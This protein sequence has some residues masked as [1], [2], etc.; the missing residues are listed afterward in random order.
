MGVTT[1]SGYRRRTGPR[2]PPP[3]TPVAVIARGTTPEQRIARTTL[4]GLAAVDLGTT[5]G[6]RGRAGGCARRARSEFARLRCRCGFASPGSRR[7]LPVAD[8]EAP[9]AG[10]T[11]VVTRSGRRPPRDCWEHST[12][13]ARRAGDRTAADPAGRPG[14]RRRRA[15]R[16]GGRMD[17]VRLGGLH[18]GQRRRPLMAELARR[19]GP[20]PCAGG[21]S[22]AGH[23]G[24]APTHR[25]RARPGT[26]RAQCPRAG[27]LVPRPLGR[28]RA[29]L[30]PCADM[31][32]RHDRGRVGRERLDGAA[33]RGVPHGGPR[34]ARARAAGGRSP[35]PT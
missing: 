13:P 7:T 32:A 28:P 27:R 16:R 9:L 30:F 34:G 29:V 2:R 15:A 11:V 1:Q 31:R 20:R 24:C 33:G 35:R 18:V 4:A 6:D 10:R 14:R 12:A 8:S 3:E 22:R 26:R 23:R 25:S 19:T 17:D 5:S 21:R